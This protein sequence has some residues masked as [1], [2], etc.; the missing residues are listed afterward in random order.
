M[1]LITDGTPKVQDIVVGN[2]SFTDV[3]KPREIMQ[4]LLN[5]DQLAAGLDNATTGMSEKHAGK[6]PAVSHEES[7]PDLWNEEGDDFFGHTTTPLVTVGTPDGEATPDTT[8]VRSKPRKTG[9][10]GTARVRKG[11][12]GSK[13]ADGSRLK[14]GTTTGDVTPV[15][16]A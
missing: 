6:Q 14:S 7:V 5:E 13:L 1:L 15:E 12:S 10:G 8:G 16:A 3:A 9:A 11:V 2:K 4:L